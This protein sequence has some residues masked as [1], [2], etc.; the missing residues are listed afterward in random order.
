MPQF[1]GQKHRLRSLKPEPCSQVRSA[2]HCSARREQLSAEENT[3]SHAPPNGAT[4]FGSA[5]DRSAARRLKYKVKFWAI[6][7]NL[8]IDLLN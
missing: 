2:E 6:G 1:L 7:S 5:F 8:S 3:G 4:Q